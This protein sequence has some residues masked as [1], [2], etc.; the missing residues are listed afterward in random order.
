MMVE[1]GNNTLTITQLTL[2]KLSLVSLL[3]ANCSFLSSYESYRVGKATE[4]CTND[5]IYGHI[6]LS[7]NSLRATLF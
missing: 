3:V 4:K 1:S 7:H 5:V 2:A 6:Y